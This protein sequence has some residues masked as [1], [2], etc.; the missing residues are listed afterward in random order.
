MFGFKLEEGY[1]VT[2]PGRNDFM[3]HNLCEK[4]FD[5]RRMVMI[6]NSTD[7]N[8]FINV[9]L[10]QDLLKDSRLC[11]AFNAPYSTIHERLLQ[12]H[13]AARPACSL[14]Q[15]ECEKRDVAFSLRDTKAAVVEKLTIDYI[16]AVKICSAD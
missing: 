9:M 10:P 1:D 16:K 15:R 4:M 12:L 5:D 14:S 13:A 2:W 8:E 7:D 3:L 6:P 11:P